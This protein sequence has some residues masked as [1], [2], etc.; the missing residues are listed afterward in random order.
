MKKLLLTVALMIACGTSVSAQKVY[1]EIL[2]I[3]KET[4][5]DTSKSIEA[6]KVA[7]FKVDELNYMAMKT[8]DMMPDSTVGV[9]DHQAYAMY[10]FV[11]LY[12]KRIAEAKKNDQD[13]VL[14]MFKDA[15]IHNSRFNDLDQELVLS[16]YNNPN[17][18]TQFS[19]DTDWEKALIE[20]REAY[21][22]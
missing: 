10:E 18:L 6:R 22:K 4:A 14:K 3:S 20:I 15:S 21:A 2:K 11:N 9:L 12:T 13:K 8:R 5:N 1:Q 7:T 16:Y 19:L 17:Y